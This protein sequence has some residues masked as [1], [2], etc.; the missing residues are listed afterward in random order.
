MLTALYKP[1]CRSATTTICTW[2][3]SMSEVDIQLIEESYGVILVK[4]DELRSWSQSCVCHGDNGS[5]CPQDS[6]RE[7]HSG[8]LSVFFFFQGCRLPLKLPS[9]AGFC[10]DCRRCRRE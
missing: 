7:L 1:S 4:T 8:A 10:Q 2:C 9:I 5:S 3:K 6:L